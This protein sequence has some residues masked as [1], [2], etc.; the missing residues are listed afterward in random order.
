MAGIITLKKLCAELILSRRA[1]DL[2]V[3]E[4]PTPRSTVAAGKSPAQEKQREK[5]KLKEA[6]SFNPN[7]FATSMM[8]TSKRFPPFKG[9]CPFQA[10]LFAIGCIA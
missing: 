6:K 3:E 1:S 4:L 10:T 9:R 8:Q 7:I 5:R 2:L